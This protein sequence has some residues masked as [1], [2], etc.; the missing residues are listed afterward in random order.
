LI[1]EVLKTA[2]VSLGEGRILER[3][4]NIEQGTPNT[5]AKQETGRPATGNTTQLH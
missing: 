3:G 2:V 4:M 5:K 1:F